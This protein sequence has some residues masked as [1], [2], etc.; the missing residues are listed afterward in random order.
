MM[1]FK[2]YFWH[3]YKTTTKKLK[4]KD[5]NLIEKCIIYSLR[6]IKAFKIEMLKKLKT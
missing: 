2:I 1:N 3:S 5:L 4:K 6:N